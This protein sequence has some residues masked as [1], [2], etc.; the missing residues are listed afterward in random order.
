MKVLLVGAGR[1]G[2]RHLRVLQGLGVEVWVCDRAPARRAWAVRQ[3]VAAG[4]VVADPGPALEA[5]DAVDVVTPAESHAALA[6]EALAAG[7][8]TFVEKPL[9]LTVADGRALTIAARQAGRV[10]QV[11]HVFRFHP[12]TAALRQALA[13]GALGR[14]RYATARFS[15][16]KRPRA[17]G[18]VTLNDAIHFFDLFAH[19]LGGPATRVT[20]LQRDYLGRGHD[21]V[22]VSVVE[23]GAVPVVVEASYFA[24]GAAREC[25][26]VGERG[27]LVGDYLAGTV[28]LHRGEH[29]RQASGWEAVDAGKEVLATAAAEPLRLELQAF[30]DACAGQAPVVV[31]AEDGVRALAV[32]EAA[33]RSARLGRAVAVERFP[34]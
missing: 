13:E 27:A 7:R 16:F 22:A 1:W 10:L 28:T 9:A 2:E 21:D 26:L 20:A 25:A 19:L 24:P 23:Y 33:A 18:G 8:H 15:A 30:L 32:V 6:A 4:R 14:L 3:G 29:R 11:G 34:A 5:V 31:S 12:V 17:D